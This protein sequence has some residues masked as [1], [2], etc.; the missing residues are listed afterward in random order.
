[1]G[2]FTEISHQSLLDFPKDSVCAIEAVEATEEHTLRLAG[3]GLTAGRE[4]RIVK[5]GEPTIVQ[6]YGTRIGLAKSLA[7]DVRVVANGAKE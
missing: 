3:L 5:C 1:M 6:V 2:T 7:R 4:V